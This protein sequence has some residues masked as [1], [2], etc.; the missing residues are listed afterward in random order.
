MLETFVGPAPEGLIACHN[1]GNPAHNMLDNLRWDTP[2]ANQLDSTKHGRTKGSRTHCAKGHEF[3]E[4][5]T[6][7]RKRSGRECRRC[8]SDYMKAWRRS[9]P[10][11]PAK[12]SRSIHPMWTSN[13]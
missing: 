10:S 9:H 11:T 7:R 6:L 13:E 1:D 12:A 5:N 2:S 3:T 8:R 4:A